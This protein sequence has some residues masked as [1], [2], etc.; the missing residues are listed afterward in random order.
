MVYFRQPHA[1][2]KEIT[3]WF[4]NQLLQTSTKFTLLFVLSSRLSECQM[5][6]NAYC[7]NHK[8]LMYVDQASTHSGAAIKTQKLGFL[9]SNLSAL[10]VLN[11]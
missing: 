4:H 9:P 7:L 2:N 6:K 1:N 3:F 11:H 5:F 10:K 8:N